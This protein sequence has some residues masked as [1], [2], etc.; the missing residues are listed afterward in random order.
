M[1]KI[2]TRGS[3]KMKDKRVIVCGNW[4][5]NLGPAAGEGLAKEVSG[6]AATVSRTEVWVAPPF[7]TIPAVAT[8]LKGGAVALGSQNVHWEGS[9]A[10]TGEISVPMLQEVG[11]SFAIV[12]HS[13]RRTIFCE[14]SEL[15]S[16][17]TVAALKAGF[18]AV[19]CIGETL[20]ERESNRTEQVLA[21]Q[22]SP[23]FA[24]LS[25]LSADQVARLVLAYEP[26]WAIGTGKVASLD[27]ISETHA[28]IA[29]HWSKNL[30]HS[31][32]AIL[33]GGSVKP[34][35]FADIIKIDHVNGALVGGAS[36]KADQFTELIRIAESR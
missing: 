24:E 6:Y 2:R 21:E 8:A 34:D 36:L 35:N 26:V 33:Y 3:E 32:P 22:F 15:V 29:D 11:A 14:S 19:L 12:G 28:F 25:K 27:Q 10:Y 4:K 17:R 18:G 20:D 23:V 16:R 31:C 7:L 30:A 5:M 9:G 1:D 13:E